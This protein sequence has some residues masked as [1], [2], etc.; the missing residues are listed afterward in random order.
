MKYLIQA[1]CVVALF[2][3]VKGKFS[4]ENIAYNFTVYQWKYN[5]ILFEKIGKL[6]SFIKDN[7][8]FPDPIMISQVVP[9]NKAVSVFILHYL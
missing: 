4:Q 7:F 2:Q 1:L 8:L 3:P 5:G 9:C 6:S